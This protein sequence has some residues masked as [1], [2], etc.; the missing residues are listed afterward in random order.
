[1]GKYKTLPPADVASQALSNLLDKIEQMKKNY[2]EKMDKFASDP[3]AQY[4]YLTGVTLWT[5]IMRT[6][7]IRNKISEAITAARKEYKSMREKMIEQIKKEAE[8]ALLTAP[9][10]R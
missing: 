8:R 5:K 3:E 6:S 4:R 10:P 7:A 9:P 2:A 1:M